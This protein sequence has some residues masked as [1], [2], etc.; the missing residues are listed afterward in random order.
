MTMT[1]TNERP[2]L[3][4]HVHHDRLFEYCYDPAE[5]RAY[6]RKEKPDAEQALRLR[7]M[8]PV[9]GALWNVALR[10]AS[11][12][13][14][15][16]YD[17]AE[18]AVNQARTAYKRAEAA[19]NQ[20]RTA[21]DKARTAYDKARTAYVHSIPPG[22]AEALHAAECPSCPWDGT[23]IFPEGREGTP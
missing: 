16:A 11:D 13:A 5:R 10:A 14:W 23:T 9:R 21:Y 3:Y 17:K 6:I 12:K 22:Q 2:G 4:W 18:A 8:Q 15:A 7:L 19:V 20:A 1:A